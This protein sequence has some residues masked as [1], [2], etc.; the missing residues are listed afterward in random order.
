[1]ILD[2]SFLLDLKDGDPDAFQAAS[3]L[4]QQ[5]TVQR[6]ALPSVW[7]L[8]YGVAYANS[9][10]ERRKVENLLLMYPRVEL[11]EELAQRGGELLA[12]ADRAADGTSGVDY[13]DALIGAAA[14]HV[15][16]PVLTDNIEDFE[17]LGIDVEMY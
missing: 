17:T 1:M 11:T 15:Q 16:E 6:V 10:E 8:Y 7:E 3:E 12:N 5:D 2:T 4:Y 9:S 14:E 13:E